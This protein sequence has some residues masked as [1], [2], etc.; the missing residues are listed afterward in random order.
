MFEKLNL[1]MDLD[2]WADNGHI[3]DVGLEAQHYAIQKE[4]EHLKTKGFKF[5][6]ITEVKE[7]PSLNDKPNFACEYF[8]GE[9][10]M[11]TENPYVIL[12]CKDAN[13]ASIINYVF[14]EPSQSFRWGPQSLREKI[15]KTSEERTKKLKFLKKE[16]I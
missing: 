1:L 6:R 7:L 16:T 12:G 3:I 14:S 15:K 2:L 4:L 9:E 10:Y 5:K 13:Q 11:G 8:S